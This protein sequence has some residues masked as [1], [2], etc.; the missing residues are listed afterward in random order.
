MI[1]EEKYNTKIKK[2]I[3]RITINK[4]RIEKN[5]V[6]IQYNQKQTEKQKSNK[7]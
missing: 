4:K 2:T 3:L 7:T 6:I 5:K 1:E